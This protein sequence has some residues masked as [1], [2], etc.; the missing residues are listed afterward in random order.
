MCGLLVPAEPAGPQVATDTA[1][2]A[3]LSRCHLTYGR[4]TIAFTKTKYHAGGEVLADPNPHEA[5]VLLVPRVSA[6][7]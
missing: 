2:G 1:A 6:E 4:Q 7:A 3:A 5:G